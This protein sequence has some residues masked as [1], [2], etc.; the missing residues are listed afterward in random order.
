MSADPPPPERPAEPGA[1]PAGAVVGLLLLVALSYAPS[2]VGGFVWDDIPLVRDNA[3]LRTWQ[4]AR[5]AAFGDLFDATGAPLSG[6]RRPV[7]TLL[8]AATLALFGPRAA[9]FRITNLALHLGAVVLLLLLLRRLGLGRLPALAGAAL[10]GLHPAQT[11]AVAFVSARPDLLTA[12]LGLTSLLAWVGARR[13][14]GSKRRGRRLAAYA[15]AGGALLLALGSKETAL[16][17]PWLAAA[18]E[19]LGVVVVP[20][21]GGPRGLRR[22]LAP[23]GLAALGILLVAGRLLVA[24]DG[25]PGPLFAR[26]EQAVALGNLSALYARLLVLPVGLRLAYDKASLATLGPATVAGW[27]LWP[28]LAGAIWAL[29]RRAPRVALGLAWMA[30]PLLPVLHLVPIASAAAERYLYLPCAGLGLALGAGLTAA[31]GQRGP[32]GAT[33]GGLRGGSARLIVALAAVGLLLAAAAGTALRATDWSSEVRLW[34]AEVARGEPSAGTLQNLAAALAE[35][36]HMAQA[37]QLMMQAWERAP[38]HPVVFRTL[39]RLLAMGALPGSRPLPAPLRREALPE[40]LRPDTPPARL[41]SWSGRLATEGHPTL[42]RVVAEMATARAE[43]SSGPR[44]ER[45][46]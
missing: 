45:P 40:L 35:R 38:G 28:L 13:A 1:F 20:R 11:E 7:P 34:S 14:E 16:L 27:L 23:A 22:W 32:D 31:L 41:R 36:G 43:A 3:A 26:G 2:L 25:G 42:A 9:P 12:V 17:L 15:G 18:A 5:R 39:V 10:F 44:G 4:G 21:A 8:N 19:A 30:L 24:R 33:S 29:R 46:R 37:S 6:Y